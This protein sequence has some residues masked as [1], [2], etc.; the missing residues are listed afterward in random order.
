MKAVTRYALALRRRQYVVRPVPVALA[1]EIIACHHYT[2]GAPNAGTY[3]HG[4]FNRANP[5]RCLGVV[6]WMPPLPGAAKKVA[7]EWAEREG[8]EMRPGDWHR[9]LM[10][11]RSCIVPFYPGGMSIPNAASFLIASSE[12]LIWLDNRYDVLLTY[13]DEYQ[14]RVP[15]MKRIPGRIYAATNWLDEGWTA[16]RPVYR[17]TRGG[18]QISHKSATNNYNHQQMKARGCELVGHFRMRRYTKVRPARLRRR[19][20]GP[21]AVQMTL[22]LAS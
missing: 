9:V 17:T 3:I 6:W 5:Q 4:L 21:H 22:P 12:Y 20:R 16:Q 15:V 10:L 19:G 11:S 2:G 8:R 7:R 1:R 13:A 14:V 18:R